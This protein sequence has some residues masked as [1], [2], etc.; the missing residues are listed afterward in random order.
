MFINELQQKSHAITD[1]AFPTTKSIKSIGNHSYD[2]HK[3][4]HGT[5]NIATDFP[6]W[7]FI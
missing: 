4:Y 6:N 7:R 5:L 3:L 2:Q 1:T